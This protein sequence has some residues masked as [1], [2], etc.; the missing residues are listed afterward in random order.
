MR[1]TLL[2][3]PLLAT[4]LVSAAGHV[5]VAA[6]IQLRPSQY[7]VYVDFEGD[8]ESG[9]AFVYGVREA[10][11]ESAGYPL[12]NSI[13]DAQIVVSILSVPADDVLSAVSLAV[14]L[15]TPQRTYLTSGVRILGRAVAEANG[16]RT[17]VPMIDRAVADFRNYLE[18]NRPTTFAKEPPQAHAIPPPAAPP[19]NDHLQPETRRSQLDKILAEADRVLAEMDSA[20][21]VNGYVFAP[22]K[23]AGL[24][25][26][27]VHN[28]TKQDAAVELTSREAET[29]AFYV[30]AD[31]SASLASVPKGTYQVRFM[32]GEIWSKDHF[33][34]DA[35]YQEFNNALVFEERESADGVAFTEISLTLHTMPRGNSPARKTA[36]F[37]ILRR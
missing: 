37:R 31:T 24:G 7:A 12:V 27:I 4:A 16:R 5:V 6:A 25:Q 33:E 13:R 29:L 11:R 21:P 26:I 19:P 35:V 3:A 36:P 30:H 10:F 28:G 15:N 9:A 17:V 8:D 1:C 2:V 34:K 23:T 14:W 18:A 20:R 32:T 22:T